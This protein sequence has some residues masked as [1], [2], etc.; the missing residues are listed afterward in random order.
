MNFAVGIPN[1]RSLPWALL[2]QSYTI[3][4]SHVLNS[5]SSSAGVKRGGVH[6]YQCH[7]AEG[8]ISPADG[9]GFIFGDSLPSTQ[10]IQKVARYSLRH[11]ALQIISCRMQLR[12]RSSCHPILHCTWRGSISLLLLQIRT[13]SN[14]KGF[15]WLRISDWCSSK[16]MHCEYV[17]H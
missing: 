2:S 4:C 13:V 6:H 1:Q 9:V 8:D 17:C 7:Y 12:V 16:Q 5:C 10:N 3:H 14:S 11:A 15:P